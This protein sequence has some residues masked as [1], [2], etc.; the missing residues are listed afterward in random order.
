VAGT[1]SSK[2]VWFA[3]LPGILGP[4]WQQVSF[5][6]GDGD[7]LSV[8]DASSG[9]LLWRKNIRSLR[10]D[11]AGALQR[12]RAG[13]RQDA[14]RQPRAAVADQRRDRRRH[15][16]PEIARTTVSM[17]DGQDIIASPDGWIPD[18]GTT[19]TGNNV[20]ACVDRVGGAARPTSATSARS[21]AT[22]AG[23]QPRRVAN[24]RDFLGTTPRD[25]SIQPAPSGGNPN[26]GDTPTGYGAVQI[27]FRRGAV[28]QLFYITNWY[29][30]QLFQLGFDEAAGNFQNTNFSGMG[31]A[32]TASWPTRRILGTNNANFATRRTALRVACRCTASPVRSRPRR[33]PRRRDRHARAHPRHSNRLIGNG[34]GLIW[35]AGGGMGEGWSDFVALSL[36]NNTNADNPDAK[37]ASG[38]YATYQLGGLTDNY[39]YGIRRFPT[40]PTTRSTRCPGRDRRR[41]RGLQRRHSD[42]PAR[43]R[44]QRRHEVH[45]IG[46]IWALTL[47]EVR[48][49]VIADPAGANGDVPTGNQTMLQIV[50]DA[51]KLTPTNPSYTDARDAILVADCAANA[52]ANE[53]SIWGGFADRGLG[54]GAVAPLAFAGNFNFGHEAI[55][56][57]TAL[58]HLDV[59]NVASDVTID[60]TSG[61]NNGAIDPGEPIRLTVKLS[62]PWRR[63]AKGVASATAT[64]TSATAGVVV[65]DGASTYPAIAAQGS[66]TGDTFLITVPPS[67]TCGQSLRF[68]ITSTSSLGCRRSTSPCAWARRPA[69][70]HRSPTRGRCPRRS[71]SPTTTRA[72]SSTRRRSPTTTRSPTSTS[73]STT[74]T[75]R[76]PATSPSSSR[77]TTAR[78]PISSGSARSSSAAAMATTSSTP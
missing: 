71:R 31:T 36:L 60:D 42:Q 15:A 38:A 41:H 48:S 17:L 58:P 40:A 57:S 39:V 33:R 28:T 47:W 72:A 56:T 49:R 61:N 53:D 54:Y 12:L 18:G 10:L 14:R 59:L 30:D 67:A 29:H 65:V 9:D 43:L 5:T 74:S 32:A 19:T 62:N 69:P 68:T 51:L 3:K 1:V 70:E 20:D 46:E 25:F 21:T 44:V 35:D 16:V 73:A 23:R 24:N 78:E 63:A 64:L 6:T 2:L 37:T 52:C 26:A 13:R 66:A 75:T 77:A 22:D 50:V 55:G 45:N 8:V 7:Y 76:S 4:A 11:P 27:N 34:A